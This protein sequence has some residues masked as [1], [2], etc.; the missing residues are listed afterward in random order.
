M[1]LIFLLYWYWI[2]YLICTQT[3]I[4]RKDERARLVAID[5]FPT[6]VC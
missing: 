5:T 4:K 3:D 1:I 6:S 2:M